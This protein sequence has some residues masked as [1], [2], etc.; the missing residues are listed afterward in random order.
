MKHIEIVV[1]FEAETKT[2]VIICKRHLKDQLL[3]AV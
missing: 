1:G 2:M 3:L